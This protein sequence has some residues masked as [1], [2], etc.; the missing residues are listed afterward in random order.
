MAIML[1][2]GLASKKWKWLEEFALPVSILSTL[3]IMY[4]LIM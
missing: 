2:I 4:V 3:G 1:A